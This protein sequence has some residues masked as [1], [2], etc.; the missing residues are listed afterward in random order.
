[1]QTMI[2][3]AYILIVAAVFCGV[4]A[5]FTRM[6]RGNN[7]ASPEPLGPLHLNSGDVTLTVVVDL[8][9][10]FLL[11]H[12]FQ[13]QVYILCLVVIFLL[14]CWVVATRANRRYQKEVQNLR[15]L[16]EG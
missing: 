13:M 1:M 11:H 5:L 10:S 8:I 2:D 14:S 3:P 7:V 6:S 4:L 16:F 9:L 12:V 15:R